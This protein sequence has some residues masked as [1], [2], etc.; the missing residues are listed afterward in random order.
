MRITGGVAGAAA[1]VL[2]LGVA[3][4]PAA[5]AGDVAGGRTATTAVASAPATAPG[6]TLYVFLNGACNNSGP[7][8]QAVPFCTVQEAADVVNP[9]QTVDITAA[10]ATEVPESVSITRSGTPGEPITFAWTGTGA[11]PVLSPDKQTGEAVVTLDDVHDVTLSRLTIESWDTDDAIDVIGS[12]DI[13]LANLHLIHGVTSDTVQPASADVMIDGASSDVTVARTNFQSGTPLEE[14]L[15]KTGAQQ[16]T[17]A[18]NLLY[19]GGAIS[20]FTLDGATDA[21]VTNNTLLLVC[22]SST[23]ARTLVTMADGSSGSVENNILEPV[24]GT[25]TSPTVGLSVDASSAWRGHRRLQRVLPR[26]DCRRL[27]LG[28]HELRRPGRVRRHWPGYARH[29]AR[30]R[31]RDGPGGGV[32]RHQLRQLLRAG[33]AVH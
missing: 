7:G 21:A 5:R 4:I 32:A 20:G 3:A 6:T 24:G 33:C 29:H 14:V 27:L 28:G 26:G 8:T 22:T 31:G 15:A 23:L 18:D 16:V 25:C 2:V 13:S 12:S 30:G 1:A 17:L 11:D 9:G 10:S 19:S